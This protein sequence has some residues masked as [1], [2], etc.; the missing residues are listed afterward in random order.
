MTQEL[1]E[2]ELETMKPEGQVRQ[3]D[4]R[5]LCRQFKAMAMKMVMQPKILTKAQTMLKLNSLYCSQVI[6]ISV[7]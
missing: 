4:N 2:K 1:G 3:K 6:S 5:Y 7:I